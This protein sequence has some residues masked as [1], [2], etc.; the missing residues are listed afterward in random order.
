[1]YYGGPRHDL[2]LYEALWVLCL[3]KCIFFEKRPVPHSTFAMIF[4]F[5]YAP[6]RFALDF[7]RNTDLSGADV[8]FFGLTPAQ[9]GSIVFHFVAWCCSCVVIKNNGTL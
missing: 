9:Y 6:I 5:G 7:L 2:G 1:M 4:C 8:R 3:Y